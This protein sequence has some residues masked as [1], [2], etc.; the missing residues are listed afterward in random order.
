MLQK[1][2]AVEEEKSLHTYQSVTDLF[3]ILINDTV[4]EQLQ[5][6]LKHKVQDIS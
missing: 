4:I 5:L 3:Y 1:Y 2:D 6:R